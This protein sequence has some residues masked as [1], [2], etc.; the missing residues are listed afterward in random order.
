MGGLKCFLSVNTPF[1]FLYFWWTTLDDDGLG[2][3]LAGG[4]VWHTSCS[5]TK[6]KLKPPYPEGMCFL[7]AT[8]HQ[9]YCNRHAW[10]KTGER[11]AGT[12][13]N[14][15]PLKR[16]PTCYYDFTA[17]AAVNS[18]DGVKLPMAT[19]LWR[20]IIKKSS[21]SLFPPCFTLALLLC[22]MTKRQLILIIRALTVIPHFGRPLFP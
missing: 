11:S 2:S 5:G 8:Q 17:I 18:V 10:S 16:I 1:V 22:C 19:V 7:A 15:P 6:G 14:Y 3:Y 9:Y 12:S 13:I 21:P 20:V 4:L